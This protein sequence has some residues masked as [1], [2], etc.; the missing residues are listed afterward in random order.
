[1]SSLL[2]RNEFKLAK[3]IMLSST[4]LLYLRQL[5]FDDIR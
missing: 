4:R 2:V 1:M 5:V 3:D